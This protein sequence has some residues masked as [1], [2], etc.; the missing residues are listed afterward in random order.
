MVLALLFCGQTDAGNTP[1]PINDPVIAPVIALVKR[2][3]GSLHLTAIATD[4]FL[5]FFL[6]AFQFGVAMGFQPRAAFI[7]RN[8]FFKFDAAAFKLLDNALKLGEGLFEGK[9]VNV[10]GFLCHG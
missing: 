9:L 7:E 2:S 10:V 6:R 8:R 3:G 1:G 5:D 4:N